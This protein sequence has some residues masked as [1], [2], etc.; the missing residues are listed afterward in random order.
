MQ[1]LFSAAF[2]ADALEFDCVVDVLRPCRLGLK[3]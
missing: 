2:S 3:R 1:S